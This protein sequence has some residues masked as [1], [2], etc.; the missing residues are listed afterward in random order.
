[1]TDMASDLVRSG[2]DRLPSLRTSFH[3]VACMVIAYMTLSAFQRRSIPACKL[4]GR[5]VGALKEVQGGIFRFRRIPHVVIVKN[6]LAEI[7]TEV[8]RARRDRGVLKTWRRRI[9]V[10]IE[11]WLSKT[12]V[13]WP[14][15]TAADFMGISL[16]RDEIRQVGSSGML[17]GGAARESRHR[18]IKTSPE[19]V[20]RAH[21]SIAGAAE[22]RCQP[23]Q[24]WKS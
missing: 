21:G 7:P 20:N 16:A 24:G 19:E 9:G 11:G 18:Q 3:T 8:R 23:R 22:P 12:A 4:G 17:R 6:E 13:S 1:M 14:E 5:F 2:G 10:G 15:P